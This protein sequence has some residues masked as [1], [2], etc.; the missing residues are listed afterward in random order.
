MKVERGTQWK[1][2]R[3]KKGQW[4]V[5]AKRGEKNIWCE[6]I[7]FCCL[8]KVCMKLQGQ[9]V[10]LRRKRRH[11]LS[12]SIVTKDLRIIGNKWANHGYRETE[13]LLFK[14]REN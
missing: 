10:L 13:N 9:S 2:D 5:K 1:E 4:N 8:A 11:L 3:E 7:I 14:K 12:G 6:D